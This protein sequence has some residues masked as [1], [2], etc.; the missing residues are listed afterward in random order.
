MVGIVGFTG[1]APLRGVDVENVSAGLLDNK[2]SSQTGKA[3]VPS[4]LQFLATR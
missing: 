3:M 1:T 4:I 2:M